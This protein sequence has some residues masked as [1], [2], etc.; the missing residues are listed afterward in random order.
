MRTLLPVVG[1]LAI[2]VGVVWFG[3]ALTP[4]GQLAGLLAILIG[5]VALSS[6]AIIDAVERAAPPRDR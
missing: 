2:F 1:L 4:I 6:S 5:V 3:R